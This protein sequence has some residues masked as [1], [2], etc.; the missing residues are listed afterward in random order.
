MPST[1]HLSQRRQEILAALLNARQV[2]PVLLTA[3]QPGREDFAALHAAGYEVVI[4]LALPT[5]P[6]ALPDEADL[7]AAHDLHYIALPVV[8]EAPTPDDLARFFAA[9]QASA[10]RSVLVHCALNYRAS[11]FVYLYRVLELGHSHPAARALLDTVWQPD[12]V[13]TAFIAQ[14]LTHA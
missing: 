9:M 10:G 6:G 7:A 5:S 8:W 4:N 11:V 14:A 12:A 13:W 1:D 2:S 3:G